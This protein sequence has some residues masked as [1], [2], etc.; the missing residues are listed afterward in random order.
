MEKR[1]N[2]QKAI[3]L[4]LVELQKGST[5]SDC[6][7]A[8]GGKWRL[9]ERTF[10]RYWKEANE[11]HN[12]A[13]EAIKEQLR[14]EVLEAEKERLKKA[15]L[16]KDERMGIASDIARGK[17][18]EVGSSILSPTAGDRLRALDYLAKVDGDY[19]PV[20]QAVSAKIDYSELSEEQLDMIIEKLNEQIQ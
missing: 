1:P 8:L 12:K 5:Y 10:D 11:A 6:L 7:A 15:I 17:P 2:K 16:T 18:W 14:T 4:I 9:P 13:R 19:A 20:K 3:D